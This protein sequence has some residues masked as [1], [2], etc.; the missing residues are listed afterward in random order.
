M[1]LNTLRGYVEFYRSLGFNILPV[2]TGTKKP[3]VNWKEYQNREVTSDE[4]ERWF[5]NNNVGVCVVNGKISGNHITID[6]D[7]KEPLTSSEIIKNALKLVKDIVGARLIRTM[8]V[9]SH[10]SIKL[11]YFVN[12]NKQISKRSFKVDHAEINGIDVLGE[13]SIDV[14]PPSKHPSG[15]QYKFIKNNGEILKPLQIT[16]DEFNELIWKLEELSKNRRNRKDV[17]SSWR[18]L[19]EDAV[20]RIIKAVKPYWKPG[21]RH[22]LALG[23]GGLFYYSGLNLEEALNIVSKIC[24]EMEDEEIRDRLRAVEDSYKD[25][26]TAYRPFFDGFDNLLGE[27]LKT[28][29]INELWSWI[30]TEYRKN[31]VYR[32]Y[33]RVN[34]DGVF[35]VGVMKDNGSW[36]IVKKELVISQSL[37]FTRE[38]EGTEPRFEV[39]VGNKVIVGTLRELKEELT[40]MGVVAKNRFIDDCLSRLLETSRDRELIR[41]C[42]VYEMA[43]VF[44]ENGELKI[45]HPTINTEIIPYNAI[46]HEI[47]ESMSKFEADEN[48]ER[49]RLFARLIVGLKP[50]FRFI[51]AGYSAISPFFWILKESHGL[52]VTPH[53]ML[54]ERRGTGKSQT[55]SV[56]T[57]NLYGTKAFIGDDLRTEFR[58]MSLVSSTT[59][60]LLVDEVGGSISSSAL[61]ILKASSTGMTE[62]HRGLRNQRMKEYKLTAPFCMTANRWVWGD[63]ALRDGRIVAIPTAEKISDLTEEEF[64]EIKIALEKSKKL[65]GLYLLK[66]VI[67]ELTPS[68]ADLLELILNE[69]LR[70]KQE[71]NGIEL[72]DGRRYRMYALLRVGYRFWIH[73][74]LRALADDEFEVFRESLEEPLK[75]EKFRKSVEKIERTIKEEKENQLDGVRA[76][77][78]YLQNLHKDEDWFGYYGLF[79]HTSRNGEE[80]ILITHEALGHYNEFARRR[81]FPTFGSLKEMGITIADILGRSIQ[82]VYKLYYVENRPIR[83]VGIPKSLIFE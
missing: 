57:R 18:K 83:S 80:M 24:E 77:I 55:L 11:H 1:K 81:G 35:L 46:A 72:I 65:F 43:G 53:L 26:N 12:T 54:Y 75:P 42:R 17:Q 2:K 9:K 4:I 39:V 73:A 29:R 40:N 48:G 14:L 64:T 56:F 51:I 19:S 68:G 58:L 7:F 10:R 8:I 36:R 25:G 30:K 62:G 74:L 28:L 13:G 21:S 78:E 6:F 61:E 76:W 41:K 22:E 5:S 34:A 23:L 66:S 15:T 20:N 69:E 49:A 33:Y 71:L 50:E 82:E 37:R 52:N 3:S 79:G 32:E 45:V 60:P 44:E 67:E 16:E 31:G 27:L 63:S 59:F 38:L 47:I 70:I